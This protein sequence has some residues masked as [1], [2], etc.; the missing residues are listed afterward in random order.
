VAGWM[1][2]LNEEGVYTVPDTLR[3]KMAE[4]FCGY[5]CTDALAQEV[6]GQVYREN[7]YV[8]D[9][10]TAVAYYAA[11]A[12]EKEREG[13]AP[14]VILSTA[15]PFKFSRPVLEALGENAEG[16]EFDLIRRLSEKTK[17][18]VPPSLAELETLPERHRS[19][20]AKEE[21]GNFVLSNL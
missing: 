16:E 13:E 15:S 11:K 17:L 20:I 6:L 18:P 1:R 12:Y 14:L 2:A 21:M 7:G 9:P 19:V 10:H 8:C 5:S 4:T 3:E